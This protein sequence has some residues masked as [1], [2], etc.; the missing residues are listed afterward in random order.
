MTKRRRLTVKGQGPEACVTY[1]LEAYKGK[2]W[3]T[4]YECPFTCVAILET[5]QADS[6]VELINETSKE[7][8]GYTP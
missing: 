8:R 2:V 4:S 1:S 3:I 6:L 7:A 5:T